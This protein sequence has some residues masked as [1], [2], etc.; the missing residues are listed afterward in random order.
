MDAIYP[1]ELD[2]YVTLTSGARLRIRALHRCEEDAVRQLYAHLSPRTRYLRFFSP[3]PM[4]PDNVMRLLTC[5]DYRRKLA[6]VVEHE[7]SA[8]QEI[9]GLG[10]F[11]A[12]DETSAEVGLVVRDDWQRQSGGT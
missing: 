10:S 12:I 2:E 1:A 7:N 6:L 3:M 5:V 8:G 4:L 9:V 11:D